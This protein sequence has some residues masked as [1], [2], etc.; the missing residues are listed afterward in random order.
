M[1][2]ADHLALEDLVGVLV[3]LLD[4]ERHADAVVDLEERDVLLDGARVVDRVVEDDRL[5]LAEDLA[6]DALG[7]GDAEMLDLARRSGRRAG[8][9]ACS[10]PSSSS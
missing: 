2:D 8:L 9:A 10:S 3:A 6:G 4:D 7:G 1:E 5:L